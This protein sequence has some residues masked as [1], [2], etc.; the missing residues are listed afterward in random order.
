[1]TWVDEIKLRVEALGM[2]IPDGAVCSHFGVCFN[3]G[4]KQICLSDRGGDL[5]VTVYASGRQFASR[6]FRRWRRD[7]RAIAPVLMYWNGK[8][9]NNGISMV[10][11]LS[12]PRPFL[13]ALESYNKRLHVTREAFQRFHTAFK[14]NLAKVRENIQIER[15][16]YRD[17]GLQ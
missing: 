10:L 3:M 9:G 12:P 8:H 1:M 11:D 6:T 7:I 4:G 14:E 13:R 17:F 15:I 16:I 5:L 2:P